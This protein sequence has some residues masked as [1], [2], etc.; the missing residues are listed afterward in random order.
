[1]ALILELQKEFR[2]SMVIVTHDME[3]A[4][5]VHKRNQLSGGKLQPIS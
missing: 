3:L 5:L 1:M 4:S 2:F